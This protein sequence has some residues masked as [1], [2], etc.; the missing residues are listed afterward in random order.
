MLREYT[1]FLK[2]NIDMIMFLLRFF[3]FSALIFLNFSFKSQTLKHI[4]ENTSSCLLTEVI[5]SHATKIKFQTNC[6]MFVPSAC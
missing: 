3:E 1:I 5:S 6:R 2:N 4:V